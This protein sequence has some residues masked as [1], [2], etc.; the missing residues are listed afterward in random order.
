VNQTSEVAGPPPETAKLHHMKRRT[1]ALA[2]AGIALAGHPAQAAELTTGQ[3]VARLFTAPAL[4]PA[5][6]STAELAA[7]PIDAW[8]TVLD[9]ITRTLGTFQKVTANGPAWT[10]SFARGTVQATAALDAGSAFTRLLFDRMQSPAAAARLASLFTTTPV[11]A[12]W[13]SDTTLAVTPIDRL[14]T[15]FG[16]MATEFGAFQT[17]VPARDGTYLVTFSKGALSFSIFLDGDGKIEELRFV[18]AK[19]S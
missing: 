13:F 4:E 17:A 18:P 3:A 15:M 8:R 10:V 12:E 5:W 14:R 19:T 6:F 16:A 2:L 11:P 9:D 1:F 7:V